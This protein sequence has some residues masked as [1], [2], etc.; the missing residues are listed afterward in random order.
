MAC[1]NK[2]FLYARAT[3]SLCCKQAWLAYNKE[4]VYALKKG[5][6]GKRGFPKKLFSEHELFSIKIFGSKRGLLPKNF[7]REELRFKFLASAKKFET[8]HFLASAK[9]VLSTEKNFL[10]SAKKNFFPSFSMA[11]SLSPFSLYFFSSRGVGGAYVCRSVFCFEA[12]VALRNS[13]LARSLARSL[14]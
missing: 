9:K 12:L 3:L 7:Y 4:R 14:A 13:S 1:S 5:F 10:A 6:F 11:R 8:R 2:K